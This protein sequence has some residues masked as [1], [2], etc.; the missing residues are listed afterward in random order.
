MKPNPNAPSKTVPHL[1]KPDPN[2]F[3]LS[4]VK[5]MALCVWTADVV[6]VNV[7]AVVVGDLVRVREVITLVA[8][9]VADAL[10]VPPAAPTGVGCPS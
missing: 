8:P 9:A 4:G 2:R 7:V 1:S 5:D 6:P 3:K 10:K